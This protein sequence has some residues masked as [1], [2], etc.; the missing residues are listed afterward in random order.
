MAVS[1]LIF[2]IGAK[3]MLK[4]FK[5]LRTIV[6]GYDTGLKNAHARISELEKLVRDRTNIAVDVGFKSASHVIV[7]GRY[8]NADYIQSYSLNSPDITTLVEQLR[9][10][11]RCGEL[12]RV[13]A[14]P[15]FK[16]AFLRDD[17]RF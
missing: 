8:R 6:A 7:I 4:W 11:E 3:N 14:P 2:L 5:K 9:H 12:R 1:I 13:D 15:Q 17:H 16:V 10:M